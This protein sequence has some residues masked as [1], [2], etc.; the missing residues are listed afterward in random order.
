MN[1]PV[2]AQPVRIPADVEREDRVL[3][4]LTARQLAILS[5]TGLV[6]YGL[7]AATRL[8]LPAAAFL[9]VA[10][11]VAAAAAVVALGSRDG[12][13]LDRLLLAALRQRFTPRVQVA[14]PN[15]IQPAPAWL[16]AHATASLGA[17]HTTAGGLTPRALTLPAR[18]VAD[19][20]TAGAIDLGPDGI[21]AVCVCST[22]NFAL[23]TPGEQ[24]ALV[25]SF[26]RY[27]HSL[28]AP[29]QILIRAQRLDLSAQVTELREYAGGLPHPA[30][31]QAALEHADYLADLAD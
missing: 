17:S 3:A 11:P 16:T 19:T 24:E 14:A 25:A 7:Y 2:S 5:V 23:R 18:D 12:L 28:T 31:E 10:V 29:V 1:T 21:A 8:L 4:G 30:L 9:A 13:S 27:L 26:G 15:G 6:L 22:V 20:A